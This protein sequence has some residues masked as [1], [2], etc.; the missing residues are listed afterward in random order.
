MVV[1]KQLA[2]PAKARRFSFCHL[3]AQL[4]QRGARGHDE[5]ARFAERGVQRGHLRLQLLEPSL[6]SLLHPTD[7]ICGG[8]VPH[9]IGE[10]ANESAVTRCPGGLHQHAEVGIFLQTQ[11][12]EV[13]DAFV[14]HEEMG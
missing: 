12:G 10:V 4:M 6:V 2:L 8:A 3:L 14:W 9:R 5:H 13:V 11:L 1:S 7:L